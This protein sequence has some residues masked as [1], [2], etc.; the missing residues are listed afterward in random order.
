MRIVFMGTPAYAA[1][2]LEALI[3]AGY[4]VVA[5]FT[6]PDKPKGRGGKLSMPEAKQLALVHGIPVYQPARIR[7]EVGTLK[8]LAPDLCVTAAYGQILSEQL[9]SVPPLGTINVHASLL[10]RYRGSSP[11]NWAIINGEAYTGVTTMMTDR[12]IDTGDILLQQRVD[13]LPEETAGE[14]TIRLAQAGAGLLID[15]LQTLSKGELDRKPQQESI[16]SYYPMLTRQTGEIDWSLPASQLANL[17]RGVHPWPGASTPSPWGPL[18]VL[19]ASPEPSADSLPPGS[20]LQAD[21]KEG[22]LVQCGQGALRIT[23]LQ[24]PGGKAMDSRDF[25]RGHPI[26]PGSTQMKNEETA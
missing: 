26:S 19:A 9:L 8:A 13:I 18:K 16:M 20:I 2:C 14:L 3:K 17:V 11:A 23:R 24:A 22:L 6:Q 7:D 1:I 15:T 12:G 10:P 5:V 25:L 4:Q 21:A